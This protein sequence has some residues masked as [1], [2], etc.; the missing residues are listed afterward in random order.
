MEN[1]SR[2]HILGRLNDSTPEKRLDAL[3]GISLDKGI[4]D[5]LPPEGNE[6]N[7]HVHTTFS[8]SPYSPAAAVW[9]ARQAGLKAVGSMDHDSIGAARK[10]WRQ[11][12]SWGWLQRLVLNF[13]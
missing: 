11:G 5:A 6:V 10:P 3:K 4:I 9:F 7:N 1:I 12:R 13:G 8:F 2:E